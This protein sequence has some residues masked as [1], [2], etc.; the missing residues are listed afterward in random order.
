MQ[1]RTVA[2]NYGR[3]ARNCASLW[4]C[5]SSSNHP[6][7]LISILCFHSLNSNDDQTLRANLSPRHSC[8][9]CCN[10]NDA[11]LPLSLLSPGG[12]RHRTNL[13]CHSLSSLLTCI[14]LMLAYVQLWRCNIF[15]R[16]CWHQGGKFYII[17]V[18]FSRSA[19]V[20]S[21]SFWM[22]FDDM[23]KSEIGKSLSLESVWASNIL[24]SSLLATNQNQK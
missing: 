7:A 6:R 14:Q 19:V 23:N 22:E 24:C 20:K 21:T 1:I 3:N 13:S 11:D 5:C 12:T 10:E 16:S 17:I 18:P 9:W 15:F 4:V 8:V 2:G